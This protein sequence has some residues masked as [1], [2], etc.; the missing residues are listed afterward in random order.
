MRWPLTG[1]LAACQEHPLNHKADHH[2][3]TTLLP[4]PTHFSDERTLT[5]ISCDWYSTDGDG[6]AGSGC[7]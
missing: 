1:N 2:N 7:D 3:E 6:A 4:L 5:R